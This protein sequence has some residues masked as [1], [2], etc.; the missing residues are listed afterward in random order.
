MKK[1]EQI[2]NRIISV[3]NDTETA[4]ELN[5]L[6]VKDC[7]KSYATDILNLFKNISETSLKQDDFDKRIAEMCE[8]FDL[9]K[10]GDKFY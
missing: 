2:V 3:A 5:K 4:P 7:V 9:Y 1:L 8:R 6:V 10:A